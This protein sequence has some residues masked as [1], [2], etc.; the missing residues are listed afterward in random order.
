[1]AGTRIIAAAFFLEILLFSL[2]GTADAAITQKGNFGFGTNFGIGGVTKYMNGIDGAFALGVH[3][4]TQYFVADRV[5]LNFHF[6]WERYFYKIETLEYNSALGYYV[7]MDKDA[8]MDIFPLVAAFRVY[9]PVGGALY[10]FAGAGPGFAMYK[11]DLPQSTTEYRFL[12]NLQL[13]VEYEIRT[14]LTFRG[15]LD[16]MIP[17][18]APTD[19]GE[20]IMARFMVFAGITYYMTSEPS[21][22][23]P[24]KQPTDKQPDKQTQ[25]K[26][27]PQ[28][29]RK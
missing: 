13:G 25:T 18:I 3:L 10:G 24:A 23:A 1:M 19:R 14:N 21:S 15:M 5:A 4:D 9:F 22:Q 12:M 29:V 2:L 17:N 28:P 6:L 8:S 26:Q 20:K 7:L 27:A 11:I 16:I